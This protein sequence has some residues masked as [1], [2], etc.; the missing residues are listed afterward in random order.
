MDLDYLNYKH[1]NSINMKAKYIFFAVMAVIATASNAFAFQFS[2]VSP[3]GHTLYYTTIG[4]NIVKVRN[5]DYNCY[6]DLIIPDSVSYNGTTYSVYAIDEFAF[7][8]C[9]YLTSV[10]I[11]GSISSFYENAFLACDNL[12]SFYYMGNIAQ[13][14]NI[15]FTSSSLPPNSYHLFVDNME[16]I[17]LE[18]PNEVTEINSYAFYN[19]CS[20][21]TVT[22]PETITKIGYRTFGNC[23]NLTTIVFNPTNCT[24]G[25]NSFENSTAVTTLIVGN[26][27]T[28]IAVNAFRGLSGLTSLNIS[29][30]VLTIGDY[31][32]KDCDHVTSIVFG[33]NVQNIGNGAFNG[34]GQVQV[35]TA[36]SVNPATVYGSSSFG[37]PDNCILHIPCGTSSTYAMT[38]YWTR[39][40]PDNAVEDLM[41]TFSATTTDPAK[42]TVQ[43]IT[44]PNC[45]NLEAEI[46]ASPYH[47]FRFDH[48]SDGNTDNPRYVVVLQDTEL[49][50]F[51]VNNIGIDEMVEDDVKVFVR[52]GRIVVDGI[53]DEHVMIF[54]MA[55]KAV[56]NRDLPTGTYLIMFGNHSF[57]KVM[58]IR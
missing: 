17:D 23:V 51:F 22:I 7:S 18:I 12:T 42:G 2:A 16:V 8:N 56:E 13:W 41:Y 11:P 57:R 55:G 37:F 1:E 25:S 34:C 44:S 27:V 26:N 10:T 35:V 53:N 9:H 50:A 24:Q 15:S 48:W 3:S 39:F 29:D 5:P 32:F 19:C 20:L 43:I 46:L 58:V 33:E 28:V 6:G 47:N 31:A 45:D 4:N 52:D 54:D 38:A 49:Q 36:K 30:S 21:N 40:F 14:C